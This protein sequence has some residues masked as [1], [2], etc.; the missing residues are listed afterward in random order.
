[1]AKS[2][3]HSGTWLLRLL[4]GRK[5]QR[6]GEED[7]RCHFL[8]VC[9]GQDSLPT[10]WSLAPGKVAFSRSPSQHGACP[11]F[12][13]GQRRTAAGAPWEWRKR[14]G[15]PSSLPWLGSALGL[16][17]RAS[18]S[19]AFSAEVHYQNGAGLRIRPAVEGDTGRDA[20]C[21]L[22][23]RWGLG[24]LLCALGE[25]R[26]GAGPRL[27]CSHRFSNLPASLCV[28]HSPRLRTRRSALR[29]AK[30]GTCR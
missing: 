28:V 7:T 25:G 4:R 19:T 16:P 3:G 20:R 21:G 30:G 1:M 23:G 17:S 29:K 11:H 12:P 15:S 10:V 22:S 14:G 9:A 8:G 24:G 6:R 5:Q 27:R 13:S 18:S 26:G 2:P